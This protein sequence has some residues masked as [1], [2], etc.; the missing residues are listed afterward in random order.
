MKYA[1]TTAGRGPQDLRNARTAVIRQALARPMQK[2]SA[3]DKGWLREVG[4]GAKTDRPQLRR[5]LSEIGLGDVVMVTRLD[6]PARSTRE[7]LNLLAAITD[8]KAGFRSLGDA[9]A[10]TTTARGRLTLTVLD[11]LAEFERERIR[12]HTG[13]RTGR[14]SAESR[15]SR[16]T[17]SARRSSAATAANL[18]GRLPAPQCTQARF[19]G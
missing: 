3:N 13:G 18:S 6:R 17:S 10:A 5:L 7:L 4:S 12:I 16:R 1:A 9:W 8:R 15:S 19:H 11:G 14:A 2:H